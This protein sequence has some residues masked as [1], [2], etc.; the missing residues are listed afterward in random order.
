M[1]IG[2]LTMKIHRHDANVAIA[3][4]SAGAT[5]GA[6]RAGQVSSAI[7]RTRSALSE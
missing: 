4:P 5:T 2:M 1:P 3:P 6:A 7:A